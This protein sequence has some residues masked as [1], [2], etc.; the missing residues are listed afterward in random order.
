MIGDIYEETMSPMITYFYHITLVNKNGRAD[1]RPS[2]LFFAEG[3]AVSALIHSGVPLVG[4]DQ[5]TVQRT[6]VGI[7]AMMGTLLDGALDTLV[8]IGIHSL[9]LLFSVMIAVCPREKEIMSRSQKYI[10]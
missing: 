6:V 1:A 5:N 3:H 4:A 7:A 8:C 2:Q 10:F 9:F